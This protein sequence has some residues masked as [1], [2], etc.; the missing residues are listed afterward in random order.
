MN[1]IQ[2]I[3]FR[4]TNWCPAMQAI[5]ADTLKRNGG[6]AP[7]QLVITEIERRLVET[8]LGDQLANDHSPNQY[9]EIS[10]AMGSNNTIGYGA[11][12]CSKVGW[13]IWSL[14]DNGYD[15]ANAHLRESYNFGFDSIEEFIQIL[16]EQSAP[17]GLGT[18]K[19][20]Y[21]EIKAAAAKST[22]AKPEPQPEA[23]PFLRSVIRKVSN[24]IDRASE[25]LT[26]V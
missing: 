8:D 25:I 6:S 18:S 10:S 11:I 23:A 12:E 20:P 26:G 5:T 22:V 4:G 14:S 16:D 2:G 24:F 7:K 3:K 1:R 13:G 9:A 21:K 17:F 15:I 19:D